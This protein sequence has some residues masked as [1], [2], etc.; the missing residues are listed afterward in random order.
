MKLQ[1]HHYALEVQNMERSKDF[2]INLLNF[3][4]E[5]SLLLLGEQITFIRLGS[6]RIELIENKQR[7]QHHDSIHLCFQVKNLNIAIQTFTEAGLEIIEG[8]YHLENGW[9]SVFYQGPDGEI[10]EFLEE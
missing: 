7:K 2:Y 8:P 4:E 5:A 10:L 3:H 9:Q 6:I 1:F